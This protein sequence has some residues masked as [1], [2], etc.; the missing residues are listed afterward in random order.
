MYSPLVFAGSTQ[1]QS[2]F[3]ELTAKNN[4]TARNVGN[5][6]GFMPYGCWCYAGSDYRK[7]KGVPKDEVD[8]FCKALHDGYECAAIE[9]EGCRAFDVDY[10]HASWDVG[11]ECERLNVGAS[12][13]AIAAC[14]IESHFVLKMFEAFIFGN[15]I[16]ELMSHGSGF[17]PT[18]R[19]KMICF[20]NNLEFI[21]E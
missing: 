6:P 7:G 4:A 16:D 18:G 19:E 13:C 17:D 11:S 15:G 1:Q 2:L 21:M 10:Y 20:Q 12:E 5:L 9:I 3:N 14:K 8:G